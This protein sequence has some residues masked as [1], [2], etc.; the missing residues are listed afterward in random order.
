MIGKKSIKKGSHPRANFEINK[1]ERKA[2]YEIFLLK[3]LYQ[4]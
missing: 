1:F 3:E 2:N 4:I